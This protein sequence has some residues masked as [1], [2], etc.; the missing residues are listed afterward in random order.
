MIKPPSNRFDSKQEAF[1]H[2]KQHGGRVFKST[3][4]HPNNGMKT[5]TFVVKKDPG[6]AENMLADYARNLVSITE[7]EETEGTNMISFNEFMYWL[8]EGKIDDM[9]DARALRR[10]TMDS[11]DPD[12]KPEEKK[13]LKSQMVQGTRYGGGRQKEEDEEN[14]SSESQEKRGRGRP[15]GS[16]S[17]ARH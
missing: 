15:K 10:A 4:T 2:A 9:R 11:T 6:V 1:A 16:K 5:T 8:N 7:Y 14:G 17:G 12:Y 3:Y 13:P